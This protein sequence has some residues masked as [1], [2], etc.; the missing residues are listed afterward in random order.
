MRNFR[1]LTPVQRRIFFL[2][3]ILAIAMAANT[4]YLVFAGHLAGIGRD[5]EVLP[6]IYQWMLVI[7]VTFGILT[8][9]VAAG[10]AATHIARVYRIRKLPSR[11][12]GITV[13][14]AISVLLL[15][16]FFILSEANSRENAWI[17]LAH[18]LV[19]LLIAASYIAHRFLSSDPPIRT[20]IIRSA[21]AIASGLV[22]VWLVH[23]FEAGDASVVAP[24]RAAQ[25]EESRVPTPND[26]TGPPLLTQFRAVG[27]PDPKLPLFPSKT[28]TTTGGYLP[29]RI[30]THD[31]LPNLTQFR[32]ET[33][34]K[35]F[36]PSYF[37]GAQSCERCH[38]DIV[39]QWS[40]S[41]HRFASFNNPFYRKS[42]ELTRKTAGLKRSQFCGGCHDPAIM[43]AGN[44]QKV[45]DPLTPESQA[46]LTCLACHA[47][48]RIHDKTGN[49]NYNIHDNTESPYLFDM[50][51]SG[52]SRVVHDYVQKAKPTVHKRRM[53]QPFFRESEFCLACHKVNLDVHINDYH[54]I[55]GQ[56]DYDAWQNSGFA[57]SNPNTWYEP[58]KT[59]QCQDCHMPL[60]P[61]KYGDVSAKG[62]KV[63]SHRFFAVNTALPFIRG[64]EESIK[65]IEADLQD[66]K[67]RVD[68][69][70][71]HREDGTTVYPLN[72]QPVGLKPGEL[73]QVDVVVRNQAVGHTFPGGTNDSNEGWVDFQV[74]AGD[75]EVY[76]SG[77]VR[78]DRQVDPAAH[79]FQAILVDRN[80]DRI[81]KRNAT[82]IYTTVYAR[83]IRPSTSDIARYRFRVPTD[84]TS[85]TLSI[86]AA[87]R[88]RKFNRTFT[89][90]VYSGQ[91]VPDL[92]ITTVAESSVQLSIGATTTSVAPVPAKADQ[93]TRYNDYGVGLFLGDDTRG[94]VEMFKRVAQLQPQKMDGW[95]NQARAYLADGDLRNAESMLRQASAV[96]P[97]QPRLAFFWGQ[98]LEKAG[99]LSEAVQAYRRAL[100]SYPDSRDTWSRLGRTYWLMNQP[101][102][103]IAAY[104]QVLRIDPEDAISYHQ[105]NLAYEALAATEKDSKRAAQYHRSATEAEKGFEKYKLD[106]NAQKVTQRYR[107]SHPLDNIMSQKIV[108]HS[109]ED[110]T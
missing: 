56:D 21:V 49:G 14:A 93:W 4:L 50:A 70:A 26:G 91:Q 95:L 68:V 109:A 94:A 92:P 103:S 87:L 107:Q 66:G 24:I 22:G 23:W 43:L 59:K 53:L 78:D 81:A 72:E 96:A 12:T 35:G 84:V 13:V 32:A 48:D 25:A 15:S 39:K 61:V 38:A 97:D 5:P 37:L 88:W 85:G 90:F 34:I 100:Q 2:V 18:Q 86:H 102:D 76:H 63:R 69:F 83:V 20:D 65:R 40:S 28:T 74:K 1:L 9:A 99:R 19:A 79:F 31:D 6:G 3:T 89:E 36:A 64:D 106:D 29:S 108:I 44:M 45:I 71:L 67:L 54:W 57:H 98:W 101:A 58:P 17:F 51:K 80:G 75:R 73:V 62:G 10:F 55:R 41:A 60:E 8:F 42:V 30:L 27:D 104:N 52:L 77:R 7:H 46:G 11:Y 33:Q 16:G 110:A 105:L 82:D 47:I